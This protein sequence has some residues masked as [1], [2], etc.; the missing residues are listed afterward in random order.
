MTS[1]DWLPL[2]GDIDA[3]RWITRA[4]CRT[5]LVVVHTVVSCRRLLDVVDC[6]ESDPRVQV[7][8][9]VAPD[10]FNHTV[11]QHLQALGALVLTWQ[12]ARRER[13]DLALAAACGGLHEL[14]APVVLMAHGA[15]RGKL[16]QRG[17]DGGPAQAEAPVYGLDAPRLTRDGRVLASAL[18]L[19]HDTEQEIL[20]R[21]CPEALAVAVVAGDPCFDRLVAS[22]PWR[23]HYRRAL[24]I[25]DR[26][27]LVVV[28]STWGRNGLFG[29]APDLVPRIMDQLPGDRFRIGALLHP[30]VWSAHGHRQVRAW[31]RDSCEA[32]L[33]LPDPME[34][35]RSLLVSADHV[36]GDH[37]SV[38]AYA[39]A[40]GQP[41]LRLAPAG[42]AVVAGGSA[43]ELVAATAAR[44][45]PRRAILP[46][47]RAARPVD[48]RAVVAALTSRPG[49]AHLVIRRTLYRLLRLAEPGRHR[50]ATPVSPPQVA[51]SEIGAWVA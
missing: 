8:F 15:G 18:L 7:V 46:Q 37:G 24:G 45:H 2:P 32:G 16:A 27:E 49:R 31:L 39:A 20:R 50:R 44:L 23:R 30:A 4:G 33:I 26:Q 12:Q 28:S 14:H 36:I 29:H 11:G 40:V 1:N 9:T 19:A 48:R 25:S 43:H 21:Q 3:Q 10:A 34:D 22:R 38:T 42:P 6:I 51:P 35:W 47:L 5:V 41:I 17:R 13:F